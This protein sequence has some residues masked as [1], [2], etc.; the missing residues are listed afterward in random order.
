VPAL[1]TNA[2]HVVQLR[3]QHVELVQAASGIQ[4][5]T[6]QAP[7]TDPLSGQQS[8]NQLDPGDWLLL[9]NR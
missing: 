7:E 4:F 3:R 5:S 2:Q 1:T 8:A 9:N 6:I